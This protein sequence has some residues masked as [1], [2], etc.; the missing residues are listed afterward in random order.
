MLDR[1]LRGSIAGVGGMEVGRAISIGQ[2]HPLLGFHFR[3]IDVV[4]F[5]GPDREAWFRGGF[6]A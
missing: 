3:P 6:P 1:S 5:H 2:L 4:V